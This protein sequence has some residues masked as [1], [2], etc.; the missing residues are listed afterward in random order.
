VQK[1]LPKGNLRMRFV[2]MA[3]NNFPSQSI[4]TEIQSRQ[5]KEKQEIQKRQL[6]QVCPYCGGSGT[7]DRSGEKRYAKAE[8]NKKQDDSFFH[9]GLI[10]I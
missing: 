2:D 4:K 5:E 6:A 8:E 7:Y 9:R 3:Q 10:Y 1:K